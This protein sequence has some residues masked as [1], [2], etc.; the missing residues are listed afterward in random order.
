MP[1]ES[2]NTITEL[3]ILNPV[4]GDVKG[5][6]D[7]HLRL[8]KKV[9][10]ATFPN[11]NGAW[12]RLVAKSSTYTVVANDNSVM[13]NCTTG[14][15]LNLTAAATL[16]AGFF[17]GFYANANIV[18]LDPAGAELVNGATTLSIPAGSWG[19]VFCTGT[20]F[21]CLT[22]VTTNSIYTAAYQDGS[23]TLAKL[24]PDT[25]PSDT[26]LV[27]GAQLG[28]RNL[29]QNSQSSNYTPVLADAGKHIY[30]TGAVATLTIPANAA[31][32]Y[33]IGTVITL[34]HKG[35]GA[36]AIDAGAVT[37]NFTGTTSVGNRSLAAKGM[38]TLLKVA[39]DEWFISGL[40]LT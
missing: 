24:A 20:E 7:D 40:G 29:P 39:T 36:L 27:N 10:K 3:N 9:L 31:V 38:A 22:N 2:A 5:E 35:S 13:F 4:S 26:T 18:L 1:L 21:I 17:F 8:L 16:G 14:I 12:Q 19:F 15:T 33:P 34:V 28:Y 32:A 11:S 6:G 30:Y 25:A 23:V 37:L